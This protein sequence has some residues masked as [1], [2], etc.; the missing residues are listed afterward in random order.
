MVASLGIFILVFFIVLLV[1]LYQKRMIESHNQLVNLEK[2]HQDR[3]MSASIEV[4]EDERR[5]IAK[6][7]HDDIGIVFQVL[8]INLNRIKKNI[9]K[10][11][12]VDD[13]VHNSSDMIDESMDVVRSIYHDIVP[14]ALSVS[15]LDPTLRQLCK[16]ISD[17]ASIAVNYT[18]PGH[19]I[20]LD[21]MRELQFYR[22]IKEVLNNT[23]KHASPLQMDITMSKRENILT[24]TLQHNGKG[25][26]TQE[27]RELAKSSKG[28]GLKSII[29]RSELLNAC[30]DFISPLQSNPFVVIRMLLL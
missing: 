6:N 20:R 24:V 18:S 2:Y 13:L 27:I 7:L 5:K 30:I 4:A 8:K 17:S 10:S 21:E 19:N 16:Q 28:L 22:L 1:R 11:Q 23:L 12:T 26:T 3:I 25:I 15:G 29:T 9:D 14:K